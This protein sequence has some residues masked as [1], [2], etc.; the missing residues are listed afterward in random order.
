MTIAAILPNATTVAHADGTFTVTPKDRTVTAA[1]SALIAGG[2][3][4]VST[5][6]ARNAAS[7]K[8]ASM[9]RTA[10]RAYPGWEVRHNVLSGMYWAKNMRGIGMGPGE[11]SFADAVHFAKTGEPASR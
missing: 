10:L 5:D 6:D 8:A 7:F 3:W 9:G 1:K 11:A 4:C 2:D